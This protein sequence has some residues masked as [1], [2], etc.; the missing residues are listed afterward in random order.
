MLGLDAA[1]FTV[2]AHVGRLVPLPGGTVTGAMTAYQGHLVAG[3]QYGGGVPLGGW[4]Y[5]R[6]SLS[7]HQVRG[8]GPGMRRLG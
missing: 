7:A 3:R 6:L 4:V 8:P 2:T 5:Y 1:N